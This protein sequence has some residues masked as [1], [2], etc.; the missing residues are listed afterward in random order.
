[1]KQLLVTLLFGAAFFFFSCDKQQ[2]F[3]VE[4]RVSFK[5]I[6][7][8]QSHP[9]DYPQ[10]AH[11][12]PFLVFSHKPTTEAYTV[13]LIATEGIKSMAETGDLVKLAEE[14]DILRGGDRALD[15]STGARIEFQQTSSVR[16]GFNDDHTNLTLVSMIAPSPDWFVALKAVDLKVNGAWVD[17]LSLSPIA[18]DAGTD[19]GNTFTSENNEVNPRFTIS[20]I[21]SLPL[22]SN[23]V[24]APL[25]QVTVVRI[26]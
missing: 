1:M 19:L 17:S 5:S 15:R 6:W 18:L 24:V 16:L 25:T 4:Y 2:E 3:P 10:A 7:S 23:G 8:A 14:I 13:G 11:F 20:E 21:N 26:K 12:S 22:A 9:V